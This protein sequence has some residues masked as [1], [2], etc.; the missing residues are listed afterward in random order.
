[1]GCW[2]GVPP[3]LP[4]ASSFPWLCFGDGRYPP[5]SIG[6]A[7]MGVPNAPPSPHPWHLPS[8]IP[9]AQLGDPLHLRPLPSHLFCL[10]SYPTVAHWGQAFIFRLSAAGVK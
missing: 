7:G 9:G 6:A 5:A 8:S 4:I 3:I 10:P 1:M 2:C